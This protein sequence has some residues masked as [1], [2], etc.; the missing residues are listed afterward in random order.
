MGAADAPSMTLTS[1]R[2]CLAVA[3]CALVVYLGA[4]RN[5]FA[6]DD[7]SIIVFNPLVQAPSGLWRAFERPYRAA[8]QYTLMY[9]RPLPVATYVLDH[10]VHKAWWFHLVNLGWHAGASIAVAARFN[11]PTPARSGAHMGGAHHSRQS[12]ARAESPE[13]ST[14]ARRQASSGRTRKGAITDVDSRLSTSGQRA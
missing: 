4:L 6:L 12:R 3:A 1:K 9:Y 7:G 14:T 10:I 2:L 8:G 5:G 11:T 13:P